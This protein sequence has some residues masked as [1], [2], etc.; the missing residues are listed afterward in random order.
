M[1]YKV[2][3]IVKTDRSVDNLDEAEKKFREELK[4]EIKQLKEENY[5]YKNL[6]IDEKIMCNKLTME[7]L[8]YKMNRKYCER[9]NAE[10]CPVLRDCD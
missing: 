9:H 1:L 7:L 2:W 5:N 10:T 8:K 3:R 6:L 4:E